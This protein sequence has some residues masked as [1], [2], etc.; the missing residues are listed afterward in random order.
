MRGC[1]VNFAPTVPVFV[2][3]HSVLLLGPRSM[4]RYVYEYKITCVKTATVMQDNPANNEKAFS[5]SIRK[6][7]VPLDL[8]PMSCMI[9]AEMV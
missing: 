1:G 3:K 9:E 6:A 5:L 8:V 4:K 2:R 7:K